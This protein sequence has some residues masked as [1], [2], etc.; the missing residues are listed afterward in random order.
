M[1]NNDKIESLMRQAMSK[2]R[3]LTDVNTVIGSPIKMVKQQLFLSQ[4]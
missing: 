4:K 1:Q 3:E 2:I